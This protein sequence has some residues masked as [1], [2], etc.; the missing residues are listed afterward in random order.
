MG[1]IPAKNHA[2]D[3][4]VHDGAIG[5]LAMGGMTRVDVELDLRHDKINFFSSEGR[6]PVPVYWTDTYA[7][8]KMYRG[9]LHDLYFDMELEGKKLQTKVSTTSNDAVI[10]STV[11]K[12]LYGFDGT[13]PDVDSSHHYR[14]MALT[15][16]GLRVTNAGMFVRRAGGWIPEYYYH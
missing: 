10:E 1:V 9:Q 12:K 7:V 16:N 6:C 14:A 8:A 4:Q 5:I 13:S 11:S 2:I 15:A 3:H